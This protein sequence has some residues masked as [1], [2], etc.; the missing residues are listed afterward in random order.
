MDARPDGGTMVICSHSIGTTSLNC[1]ITF[2]S[3]F[4]FRSYNANPL[5][6]PVAMLFDAEDSKSDPY[7]TYIIFQMTTTSKIYVAKT[8][9]LTTD[10]DSQG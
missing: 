2:V 6:R 4:L 5:F 8:Y 10:S 1:A 7:T 3:N 9:Y